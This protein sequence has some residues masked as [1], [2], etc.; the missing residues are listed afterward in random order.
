MSFMFRYKNFVLF[1]TPKKKKKF[2]DIELGSVI[3]MKFYIS[4]IFDKFNTL[5]LSTNFYAFQIK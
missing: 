3:I 1:Y 2:F 4:S 5:K